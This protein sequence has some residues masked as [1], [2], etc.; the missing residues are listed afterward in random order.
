MNGLFSSNAR[1]FGLQIWPSKLSDAQYI[2]KLRK[3]QRAYRWMRILYA[4]IGIAAVALAIWMIQECLDIVADGGLPVG[5]QGGV[6]IAL[7]IAIVIGF[8]VGSM[9]YGVLHGALALVVESRRDRML[10]ECW[11]LLQQ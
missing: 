4:L 11:D 10:V 1:F 9:I 7:I 2:E 8:N 5:Q 6:Q 3:R